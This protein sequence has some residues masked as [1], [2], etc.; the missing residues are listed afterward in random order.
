MKEGIPPPPPTPFPPFPPK[1]SEI[2]EIRSCHFNFNF[3]LYFRQKSHVIKVD[4]TTLLKHMRLL[5]KYEPNIRPSFPWAA[6]QIRV[7]FQLVAMD[8][9]DISDSV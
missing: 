5:S 7:G 1:K 9:L 4:N 8:D 2:C 6:D 3:W